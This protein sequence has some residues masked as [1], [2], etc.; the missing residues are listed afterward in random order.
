MLSLLLLIL[1]VG[2]CV[3]GTSYYRYVDLSPAMDLMPRVE[4]DSVPAGRMVCY[5]L[6]V[7]GDSLEVLRLDRGVSVSAFGFQGGITVVYSDSVIVWQGIEDCSSGYRIELNG[8]GQP[9][10]VA[11][12]DGEPVKELV[13]KSDS[14]LIS[15]PLD[16]QGNRAGIKL[17]PVYTGA[18]LRLDSTGALEYSRYETLTAQGWQYNLDSSH[19]ILFKRAVA[20][21]GETVVTSDGVAVAEHTYDNAGNMTST[22]FI[23]ADGELLPYNYSAPETGNYSFDENG[24]VENQV[25]VAYIERQYDANSL[26]IR[27]RYID[28]GGNL[29]ENLQ[30]V[31]S[32]VYRRD[33]S[34]GISESVWL[35]LNSARTEINGICIARRLFDAHGRVIESSTYNADGGIAEF[36]GGFAYTRFTYADNGQPEMISYYDRRGLPAVNSTLGCHARSFVYDDSGRCLEHRYLDTS[37]NL[38]NLLTGYARVVS[39]YNENG[40]LQEQ[41]FFDSD[42]VEVTL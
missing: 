11:G 9:V 40:V 16:S 20:H 13:W 26:C 21:T 31:A 2:I 25:V 19:R 7:S 30:G 22:R 29:T 3:S 23:N 14:T 37:Y 24:V 4:V 5:R 6:K 38:V 17:D 33:V 34:G 27:E 28:T 32:V 41:H 10:L 39:V 12:P 15:Y 1:E 36:S 35:D 18:I 42:G 8:A